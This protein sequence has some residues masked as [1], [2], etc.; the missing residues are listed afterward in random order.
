MSDYELGA[1]GLRH[2]CHPGEFEGGLAIDEL[3][4]AITLEGRADESAGDVEAFGAYDKVAL[5]PD[6]PDDGSYDQWAHEVSI[7][8]LNDAERAFLTKHAGAIVTTNAQGFVDVAYY[9]TEEELEAAWRDVE[10]LCTELFEDGEAPDEAS[11]EVRAEDRAE[12]A[13]EVMNEEAT[14]EVIAVET[15]PDDAAERDE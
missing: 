9:E 15:L 2:Q 6:Q 4:H 14:I 12:D 5:G 10:T 13:D 11:D 1:D 8:P 3:V 7:A